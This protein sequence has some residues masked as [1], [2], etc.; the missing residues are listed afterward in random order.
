MEPL[1]DSVERLSKKLERLSVNRHAGGALE[2]FGQAV[3]EIEARRDRLAPEVDIH[4][5]LVAAGAILAARDLPQE[6]PGLEE[7]P[8]DS[9]R[10]LLRGGS[11]IVAPDGRYLAG[12]VHDE[13]TVI[14]ADCDL[15]EI[16]RESMTLDVSGHYSRRDL[17]ELSFRPGEGA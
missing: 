4:L 14:P 11:A 5:T 10:L 7:E 17:F 3:K 2:V 13:E 9:S 16:D 8:T 15:T 1:S 6:L 12:P